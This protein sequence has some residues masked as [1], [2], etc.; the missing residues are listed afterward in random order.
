MIFFLF[1]IIWSTHYPIVQTFTTFINCSCPLPLSPTVET[2]KKKV[3]LWAYI[4]N[5]ISFL[6]EIF[7]SWRMI[8]IFSRC[9]LQCIQI[10]GSHTYYVELGE[11]KKT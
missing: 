5:E 11:G 10:L 9:Y 1:F 8:S 3:K 2:L 7:F 6:M 4:E